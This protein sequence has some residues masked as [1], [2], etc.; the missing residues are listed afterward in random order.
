MIDRETENREIAVS[1]CFCYK[2]SVKQQIFVTICYDKITGIK[3]S[4]RGE[5][6]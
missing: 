6:G 5:R 2:N 3:N 1:L 4:C